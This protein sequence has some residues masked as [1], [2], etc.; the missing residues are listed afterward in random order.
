MKRILVDVDCVV[1]D[2]M[3]EWLGFYNAEYDDHV[4]V[5]DVTAWGLEAFVK[6]ECGVKIYEYLRYPY[7]Y[8]N[9]APIDGALTS[10]KWLR[11]HSYDVVFVTSGIHEGKAKWLDHYGFLLS[12]VD[13]QYAPDL[14]IA[15]DK[16]LIKGDIMLDDNIKN[17][18]AFDGTRILFA[19]PWNSE[20]DSRNSEY[21]RA[22]DWADV[23]QYLG[24]GL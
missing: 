9:V 20:I 7:L 23:I 17:L 8:D 10:I 19:Q 15:H 6:P 18:L 14:V 24:R 22:D 3:P 11:R 21:F 16:G 2:L 1:A 13:Y 5:E 12:Q 4:S